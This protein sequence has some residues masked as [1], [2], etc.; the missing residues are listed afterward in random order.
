[1]FIH[2]RHLPQTDAN[3]QVIRVGVP[4]QIPVGGYLDQP[5][6]AE[7]LEFY[8]VD[9]D[10]YEYR[11]KRPLYQVLSILGA[12]NHFKERMKKWEAYYK[13]DNKVNET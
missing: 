7:V 12:R 4:C 10:F 2:K 8:K 3:K 13:R 5:C 1:L 9:E 11:G 6:E